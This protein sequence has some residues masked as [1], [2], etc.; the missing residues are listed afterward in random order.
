MVFYGHIIVFYG[1]SW[2]NIDLIGLV[3]SFLA[4]IDPNSFGLVLLFK[5]KLR[6]IRIL[7]PSNTNIIYVFVKKLFQNKRTFDV[8][9][10]KNNYKA[11][12]IDRF[13]PSHTVHCCKSF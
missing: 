1:R 13:V 4:V 7:T 6:Q 2:Q 3:S 11:E 10:S 5:A 9:A 8:M 12:T